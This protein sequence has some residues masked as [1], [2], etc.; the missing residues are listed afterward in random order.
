VLFRSY[1]PENEAK[2]VL[3]DGH[4]RAVAAG[5]VGADIPVTYTDDPQWE[6]QAQAAKEAHLH[7]R[8]F[9]A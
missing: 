2:G 4:H 7:K 5:M 9:T 6:A 1:R 3:I 8:R